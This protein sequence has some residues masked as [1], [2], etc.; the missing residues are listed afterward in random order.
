MAATVQGSEAKICCI[1]LCVRLESPPSR[2]LSSALA[3]QFPVQLSNKRIF[4]HNANIQTSDLWI[5]LPV[6]R[7]VQMAIR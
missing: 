2:D 4:I 1:A 5:G 3:P 6:G 7:F